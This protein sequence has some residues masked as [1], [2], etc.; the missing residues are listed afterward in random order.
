MHPIG[1]LDIVP[2][3]KIFNTIYT[4]SIKKQKNPI[5]MMRLRKLE[6]KT[7][8]NHKPERTA[9]SIFRRAGNSKLPIKMKQKKKKHHKLFNFYFIYLLCWCCKGI[10]F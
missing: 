10:T 9:K 4:S 3:K 5:V 6:R 8:W 7:M 1:T 2:H